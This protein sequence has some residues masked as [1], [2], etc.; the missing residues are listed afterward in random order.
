MKRN[1]IMAVA[2]VASVIL[3]ESCTE[4]I[5][6]R[7]P[8]KVTLPDLPDIELDHN[9]KAPLYWDIYEVVETQMSKDGKD[10][11]DIDVTY[12]EW[13]KITDWVAKELKPYGYD[14]VCTDGYCPQIGRTGSPYMSHYGS[15]PI[16]ELAEMCK[17]KGLKLGVY[18]S[19]LWV[20]SPWDTKIPGTDDLI[21]HDLLWDRNKDAKVEF[22]GATDIWGFQWVMTDV[23]GAKEYFD[24]FFKYYHDMGVDFIR[25]DFLSWY[26]KGISRGDD[27]PV[28]KGYGRERYARALNYIAEN[29]KKYGM[30]VSLVMPHNFED[31]ELEKKYGHMV[32]IDADTANGGWWHF[33]EADRGS[34]FTTWPHSNNMFDG[35]VYWSHISGR[36]KIILDGDFTRLNTFENDAQKRSVISLQLMAGGPISAC[37]TPDNMGENIKFYTNTEMLALNADHFCGKPVIDKL[38]DSNNQIWYG[39][40]SNGDWI[41]GM[42]NRDNAVKSVK[43]NFSD[44]GING[45]MKIRDIWT[46]QDEGVASSL[47]INIPPYDCKIIKLTK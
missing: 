21:L 12:E 31:A 4:D 44:F 26:E 22:P 3:F 2:M 5:E 23:P 19:P 33:S 43:V 37:D 16:K 18:D 17:K 36:E 30:F 7:R 6:M 11:E 10:K 38:N 40:M 8:P 13:D 15:M 9:F 42:F 35:F 41:I 32:R 25:I 27:T 39:Q 20:H 47:S 14:M 28:S 1:L 24:G 46:H 45:E 29:A 34:S